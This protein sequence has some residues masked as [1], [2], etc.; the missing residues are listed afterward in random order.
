MKIYE[1]GD[2]YDIKSALSGDVIFDFYAPWCG[3][4]K[5]M[6]KSF[7]SLRHSNNYD[8]LTVVKI[9]IDSY[10]DLAKA[11]SVRSLPTIVLLKEG[12]AIKTNVGSLSQT[13]LVNVIQENFKY[14]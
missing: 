9:N 11:Y 7:E 12:K 13:G 1:L 3:P 10:Q 4:C 2:G 8:N 5:V 14:E 6:L